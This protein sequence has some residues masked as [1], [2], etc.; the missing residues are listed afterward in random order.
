MFEVEVAKLA[1]LALVNHKNNNPALS[2]EYHHL[3]IISSFILL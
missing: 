1:K 3:G 2:L